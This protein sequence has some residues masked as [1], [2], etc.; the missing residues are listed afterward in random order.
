M[1]CFQVANIQ[2]DVR[3]KDIDRILETLGIASCA[4]TRSE[5]LSGGQRKR[6]TIA[7]ELVSNPSVIF[8]DE[9]TT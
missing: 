8:L 1:L 9:P 7:L 2:E 6:L 5:V 4:D 3:R